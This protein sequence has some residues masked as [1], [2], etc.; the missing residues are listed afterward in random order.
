M[1]DVTPGT[2]TPITPPV[3]R[4]DHVK[5]FVGDLARPFAI[6]VTSGGAAWATVVAA[7]RVQ[8]GTDGALLLTAIFAGVAVLYGAKSWEVAKVAKTQSEASK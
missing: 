2:D 6:I 8:N 5:S 7:Y 1:T 4:L 3:S